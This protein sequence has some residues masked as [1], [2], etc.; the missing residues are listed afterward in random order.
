MNQYLTERQQKI[1]D[2]ITREIDRSGIAPNTVQKKLLRAKKD[3]CYS[4]SGKA[5]TG[6]E[7]IMKGIIKQVANNFLIFLSFKP[8][9]LFKPFP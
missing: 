7:F 8:I 6:P 3:S 5:R 2:Y 1:L 9:L 4:L